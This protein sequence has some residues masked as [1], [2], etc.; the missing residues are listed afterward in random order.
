MKT[1][2]KLLIKILLAC[3]LQ[4]LTA[5]TAVREVSIALLDAG[6]AEAQI[7][8]QKTQED[9]LAAQEQ[10][11]QKTVRAEQ[12]QSGKF[13]NMAETVS[14]GDVQHT[15]AKAAFGVARDTYAYA[16]RLRRRTMEAIDGLI[17]RAE[18]EAFEIKAQ[19]RRQIM[20]AFLIASK[21]NEKKAW[22]H[23]LRDEY[24]RHLQTLE[25]IVKQ[26]EA[27]ADLDAMLEHFKT[28]RAWFV[29]SLDVISSPTDRKY[30]P[31]FQK[32]Q[33]LRNILISF[34]R[35]TNMLDER[36]HQA[37][38]TIQDI[39]KARVLALYD[40]QALVTDKVQ[41]D[42]IAEAAFLSTRECALVVDGLFTKLAARK[43][44]DDLTN[45]VAARDEQLQA[46]E[47]EQQVL[48]EQVKQAEGQV[49]QAVEQK[50]ALIPLIEGLNKENANLQLIVLDQ[51]ELA[52]YKKQVQG[53]M[54]PE[55]KEAG[56]V[57]AQ[58]QVTRTI[59]E[60]EL[61]E[62]KARG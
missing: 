53:P 4:Q 6:R 34:D 18:K 43:R 9:V 23:G 2:L 54:V 35:V 32:A 58:E 24:L 62:K 11:T 61:T 47:Q 38:L 31:L 25:N 7:I 14:T 1:N 57:Q 48:K 41:P 22:K 59:L 17:K 8:E 55:Q 52:T 50:T 15:I 44:I 49:A 40:I 16:E 20:D 26:G 51:K 3:A 10:M 45:Q 13:I 56:A 42:G 28:Q 33:A 36:V 21:N 37:G 60:K 30:F 29:E 39:D 19:K 27:A 46:A 5:A 12:G